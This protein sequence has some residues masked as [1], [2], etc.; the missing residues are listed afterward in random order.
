[1][2]YSQDLNV[3]E[4]GE[5]LEVKC[6]ERCLPPLHWEEVWMTSVTFS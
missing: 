4:V 3:K 2:G 1:M 6:T 5:Y